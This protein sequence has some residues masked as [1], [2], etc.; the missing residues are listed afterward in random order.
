MKNSK[1]LNLDS[2]TWMIVADVHGNL[3][4]YKRIKKICLSEIP[5]LE[6]GMISASQLSCCL[7]LLFLL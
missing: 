4:D 6:T 7:A 2:G 5:F 3:E 1:V